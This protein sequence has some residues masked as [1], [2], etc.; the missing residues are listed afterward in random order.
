MWVRKFEVP[1][2][3]STGCEISVVEEAFRAF[4]DLC[5]YGI[6]QVE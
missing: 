6:S 3:E 2:R 4:N 1:D 5:E